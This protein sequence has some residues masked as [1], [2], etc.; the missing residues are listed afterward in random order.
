MSTALEPCIQC[1]E[2]SKAYEEVRALNKVTFN[3]EYGERVAILGPNGAGKST[4]LKILATQ[5]TSYDGT[6]TIL[7]K[8][9]AKDRRYIRSRVG[10]L[11]H[12]S[13]LYDELTV[14]ENLVYY[15]KMF[16]IKEGY[17]RSRINELMDLLGLKRWSDVQVKKL[18]HGLRRRAD[19]ARTLLHSPELLILDEP[20]SGLDKSSV[21]LLLKLFKSSNNITIIFSSHTMELIE[22]ACTR[23][24]L[25]EHGRLVGDVKV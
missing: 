6:V 4:L 2:L 20:F 16:S 23:K 21:N 3:I 22:Q 9:P 12:F 17:L 15:G 14:E 13:F 10:F 24:L 11:G 19:L 8:N 1:K 18:S 25:F 5:I 7:G